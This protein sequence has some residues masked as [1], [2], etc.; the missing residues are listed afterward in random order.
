MG[1]LKLTY[2]LNPELKL[3]YSKKELTLENSSESACKYYPYG[4][5]I[6]DLAVD[7]G[8]DSK[9]KFGGK[10]LQDDDLNGVSLALYDFHA[11]SYDPIVPHFTTADPMS[12][13]RLWVSPY[14]YCQN[15]PILR[16]DPDGM[17]DWI[18]EADKDGNV[19]YTAERGDGAHTLS[20]QYGIAQDQAEKITGTQGAE[21]VQKD[22]KIS[23]NKVKEVTGSEILKMDWQSKMASDSRRIDQTLFAMEHSISEGKNTFKTQDYFKNIPYLHNGRTYGYGGAAFFKGTTTKVTGTKLPIQIMLNHKNKHPIES[24]PNSNDNWYVP[25][26]KMYYFRYNASTGAGHPTIPMFIKFQGKT[27]MQ[28]F[29]EKFGF[30]FSEIKR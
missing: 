26:Q 6:G 2:N 12:E 16:I 30:K 19:S 17:L 14:N 9:I 7:R 29:T 25:H 18:P 1:C 4:M 15:N 8:A 10:E 5:S 11:R 28:K 3:I 20:E 27:N 23:G 21:L 22:T 24:V 13:E